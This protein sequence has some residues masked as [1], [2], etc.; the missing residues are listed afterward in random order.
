MQQKR[1]KYVSRMR[2][3]YKHKSAAWQ[4]RRALDT[5]LQLI[6][7]VGSVSVPFLVNISQLSKLVPT[8]VSTLVA[9]AAALSNYYKFGEWG[10]IHRSTAQKLIDEIEDY[11][12]RTGR[13]KNLD[14]DQ[15]FE[16]FKER[17]ELAL[18]EHMRQVG[19]LSRQPQPIEQ[20]GSQ[21]ENR[22]GRPLGE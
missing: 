16:L 20:I 11:D 17:T 5:I 9:I 15:A 18:N 22:P 6:I 1:E 14:E 10:R 7:I 4:Q 13:Y 3:Q 12:L 21:P 8:L 19:D 2:E